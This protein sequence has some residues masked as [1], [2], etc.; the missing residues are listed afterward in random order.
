MSVVETWTADPAGNQPI[1]PG[2]L[3]PL[4]DYPPPTGPGNQR[5]YRQGAT[6]WSQG[7]TL[8]VH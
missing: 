5:P 4:Q 6:A 3:G 8:S 2:S 1:P 7:S